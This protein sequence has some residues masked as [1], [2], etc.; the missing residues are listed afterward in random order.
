MKNIF[1]KSILKKNKIKNYEVTKK[2][3][4]ELKKKKKF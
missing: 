1:N 3:W 2:L 4:L